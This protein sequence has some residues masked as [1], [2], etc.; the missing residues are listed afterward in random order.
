MQI[1]I[2]TLEKE[3]IWIGPLR[4]MRARIRNFGK[5]VNLD[6]GSGLYE[7]CGPGSE[8]LKKGCIWILDPAFTKKQSGSETLDKG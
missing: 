3:L 8:T 7:K 5:M 1:Q 6:S 2:E 4:K